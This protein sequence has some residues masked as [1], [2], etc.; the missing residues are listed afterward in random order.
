[1]NQR[2]LKS[3]RF[4]RGRLMPQEFDILRFHDWVRGQMDSA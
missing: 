1:M 4:A 2:G 3:E